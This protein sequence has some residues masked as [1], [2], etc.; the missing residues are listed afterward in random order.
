MSSIGK[1]LY[2]RVAYDGSTFAGFQS[3]KNGRTIQDQIEKAFHKVFRT[4]VR[5]HFFSRTDAGVHAL[6]Q[7]I[8]IKNGL[9]LYHSL[10][11][12]EQ[13]YL[14]GSLNY[15]SGPQIRFWDLGELEETFD[16]AQH[17]LWK[18]YFYY[19]WNA[20]VED[21]SRT[22]NHAWV[23]AELDL[24]AIKASLKH[25]VGLHDFAAFA[26]S[27]GRAVKANKRGSF[28]ELLKA[29]VSVERHPVFYE[30][31]C[32]CFRFRGKGFLQH[33]VRNL[34]G[35]LIDI[36]MGRR[37][38]IR[39]ILRSRSRIEAGRNFPAQA[40]FLHQTRVSKRVYSSFVRAP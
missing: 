26:K 13:R 4:R 24:K 40:L 19:V 5:I 15:L 8:Y 20:P 38:D 32:L 2:F 14:I 36:G 34:V 3:Q 7:W 27:S 29:E 28:R 17:V 6:D 10:K 33:M 30:S 12:R 35:T 23:R 1:H 21:P 22:K 11:K 25:L 9:E 18:E 16:I 39:K 31:Q 37:V